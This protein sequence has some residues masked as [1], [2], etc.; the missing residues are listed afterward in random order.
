MDTLKRKVLFLQISSILFSVLII[1][2]SN[3]EARDSLLFTII[4]VVTV[5][6]ALY[7]SAIEYK[8]KKKRNK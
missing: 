2:L 7:W 5:F 4:V 6:I 8:I 3:T 1:A